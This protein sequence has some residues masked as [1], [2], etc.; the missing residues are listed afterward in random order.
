MSVTFE[1]T[2]L[3]THATV[4][5]LELPDRDGH[6][7]DPDLRAAFLAEGP[8]TQRLG[9]LFDDG[10]L[11]VTT[12]QQPGLLTGPLFTVYKALTA[13]AL[14]RKLAPIL[15]RPVVPVFWVGGDD[16]DFAEAN[17]LHLLTV[18]NEIERLSLGDRTADEPSLPLY[19]NLLG[20]EVAFVIEAHRAHTPDTEFRPAVL[21]WVSR[22]YRADSDLATAFA[23]AIAGRNHGTQKEEKAQSHQSPAPNAAESGR[24]NGGTC[25]E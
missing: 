23:G 11:C 1:A 15:D 3:G 20:P 2:P 14:A 4:G 8:A 21:E 16:H 17:H 22:H 9:Q 13:V 12:G 24:G 19:R 18:T 6:V 10:A 5:L 7:L 25:P